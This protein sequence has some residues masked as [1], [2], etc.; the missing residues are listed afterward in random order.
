MNYGFET[1]PWTLHCCVFCSNALNLFL[2]RKS[3]PAAH[4]CQELAHSLQCFPRLRPAGFFPL[5]LSLAGGL[6]AGSPQE[7]CPWPCSLQAAACT[8]HSL[9]IGTFSLVD[10]QWGLGGVWDRI[11]TGE[12]QMPTGND[13]W[14]S[15]WQLQ[16]DEWKHSCLS[17]KT[18]LLSA[19]LPNHLPVEAPCLGSGRGKRGSCPLLTEVTVH[20]SGEAWQRT[21]YLRY[22]FSSK[23][24]GKH[25]LH[26][27]YKY[28]A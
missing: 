21:P 9:W 28:L 25:V 13:A 11:W 3:F 26:I 23:W 17:R 15:L 10:W 7:G 16:K 27:L 6:G 5:C 12:W 1:R 20:S 14:V 18:A 19:P 4:Q 8:A 2:F 22:N 24:R